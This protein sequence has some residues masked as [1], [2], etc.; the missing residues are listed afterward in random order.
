[1][2]EH[3]HR[4]PPIALPLMLS[5]SDSAAVLNESEPNNQTA[6]GTGIT[7]LHSPGAPPVAVLKPMSAG[8]AAFPPT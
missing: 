7:T 1:M 6:G 4:F 3:N 8:K 2:N 5:E